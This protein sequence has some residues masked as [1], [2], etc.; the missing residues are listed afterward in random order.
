[1]VRR[2]ERDC[3]QVIFRVVAP[4]VESERFQTRV[5]GFSKTFW[6]RSKYYSHVV[7]FKRP[8]GVNE[9]LRRLLLILDDI[10]VEEFVGV[11]QCY[12]QVM[13][14]DNSASV[15][16]EIDPEVVARLGELGLD[17]NLVLISY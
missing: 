6:V 10:R 15:A 9:A 7:P 14:E 3:G 16:Y 13:I 5:K 4:G 2:V 12:L 17:I 11:Y 8:E 1:M